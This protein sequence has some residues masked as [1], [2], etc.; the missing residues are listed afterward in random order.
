MNG[1]L[2][3]IYD[4]VVDVGIRVTSLEVTQKLQH[5]ENSTAIKKLIFHDEKCR[6]QHI[7]NNSILKIQW[8]L[9]S[10]IIIGIFGVAWAALK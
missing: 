7:T 8:F 5:K 10:G 6:K 1:D 2:E 9:I 3:K 4:A